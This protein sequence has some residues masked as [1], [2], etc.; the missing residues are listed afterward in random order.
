MYAFKGAHMGLYS[1]NDWILNTSFH[2]LTTKEVLERVENEV[3]THIQ[4]SKRDSK[5]II[6]LDLDSTL[7]EVGPRTLA[8]I[9]EWNESPQTPLN[10]QST[11]NEVALKHIGYSL[12]DMAHNLGLHPSHPDTEHAL[13]ELKPFWWDRFFTNHYLLHDRPYPG[14]VEYTQNLFN[15]GAHLVYLTGREQSKMEE[16]TIHNL[17]RDNFPW[18]KNNTTLVMKPSGS[19]L[20]VAHKKNIKSFIDQ[21]GTL[22][23]SFENEPINIVAL[24]QVFP[25]A[26]HIFMDTVYSDHPTEPGKNLFRIK[27][28]KKELSQP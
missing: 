1:R 10:I 18:C 14:A 23:A 5:P 28:F 24:S 7:Y 9:K 16:Q 8:I 12:S 4:G 11:L 15:M 2:P 3:K 6:L 27:S 17:K 25:H 20:D 26:M 21:N 19:V 13:N 22:L